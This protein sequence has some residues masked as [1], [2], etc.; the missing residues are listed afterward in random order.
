MKQHL[1][2]I[3]E[4]S[5]EGQWSLADGKQTRWALGLLSLLSGENFQAM[6]QREELR[7]SPW[8]EETE[9]GNQL[10][11][12]EQSRRGENC[13]ENWNLQKVPFKVSV[14]NWSSMWAGKLSETQERTALQ[15][16]SKLSRGSYKARIAAIPIIQNGKPSNSWRSG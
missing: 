4:L 1:S 16:K 3:L 10:G 8:G 15:D 11:F 7:W 13:T 14:S 2:K 12:S 6:T 5:H 9:L